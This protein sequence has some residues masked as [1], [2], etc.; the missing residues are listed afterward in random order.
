L[1][2][3][4]AKFYTVLG[5]EAM[6]NCILVSLFPGGSRMLAYPWLAF[7]LLSRAKP[8]FAGYFSMILMHIVHRMGLAGRAWVVN[9][10]YMR[11]TAFARDSIMNA[12]GFVEVPR[13]TLAD[14]RVCI[15]GS[16]TPPPRFDC[17]CWCQR[18]RLFNRVGALRSCFCTA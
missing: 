4:T 8:A 10:L 2:V 3:F 12:E 6:S 7:P 11:V 5:T 14:S 1:L 17:C 15:R 18:S 9:G 13:T 16:Y